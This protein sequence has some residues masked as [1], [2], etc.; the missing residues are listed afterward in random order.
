MGSMYVATKRSAN[1][2]FIRASFRLLRIIVNK[3]Q[4]GLVA[5]RL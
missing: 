1:D 5:G 3:K 4:D 2:G